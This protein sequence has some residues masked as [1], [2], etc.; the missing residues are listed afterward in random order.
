VAA[1][2]LVVLCEPAAVEIGAE[3]EV[4]VNRELPEDAAA[5]GDVRDSGACDPLG[6]GARDA[7]AREPDLPRG[8]D[9]PGDCSERR[10]LARAVPAENGDDLALPHAQ[11]HPTERLHRPVARVDVLELE[12]PSH[13]SAVPR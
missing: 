5:F 2:P 4:L 9:E 8:R 12:Q 11:R 13:Q 6:R 10:R 3:A 1:H 7:L